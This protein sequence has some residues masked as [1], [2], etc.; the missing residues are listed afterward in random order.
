M[1]THPIVS[2]QEWLVARQLLL[3][4]E[5]QLTRLR[6][7][8]SAERRALPWVKITKSYV[9]D[10]PNGPETLADLFGGHSQ[11]IVK[12][13]MFGP[14]GPKG[15]SAVR[16]MPTISTAQTSICRGAT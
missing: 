7:E 13:F 16:S 12:H 15:A 10:G 3:E 5:K 11:L 1:Q 6:D 2:D 14:I 9:F 4:K 8:L